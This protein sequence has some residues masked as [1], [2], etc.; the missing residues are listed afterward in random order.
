MHPET[1]RQAL[2]GHLLRMAV[3]GYFFGWF[4]RWAIS[5]LVMHLP[6]RTTFQKAYPNESLA[7]H[8][9]TAST[10]LSTGADS[11]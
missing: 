10:P 6:P 11:M 8:I 4:L 9:V 1:K 3:V 7:T 5:T 2:Y